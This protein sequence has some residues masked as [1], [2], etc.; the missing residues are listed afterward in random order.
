MPGEILHPPH[1]GNS[2]SPAPPPVP[3]NDWLEVNFL[4]GGRT[5]LVVHGWYQKNLHWLC[6]VGIDPP[7]RTGCSKVSLAGG[8][9]SPGF[10]AAKTGVTGTSLYSSS[11]WPASCCLGSSLVAWLS[12]CSPTIAPYPTAFSTI[13][14]SPPGLGIAST[15][16]ISGALKPCA[17]DIQFLEFS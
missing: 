14:P 6:W 5:L 10:V 13:Y 15:E 2:G 4:Y 11:Q 16:G 12:S 17:A 9:K 7:E 8:T 3:E 1:P